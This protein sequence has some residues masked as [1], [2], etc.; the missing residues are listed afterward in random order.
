MS[1]PVASAPANAAMHIHR[2]D[3]AAPAT[4]SSAQR[5]RMIRIAGKPRLP[6]RTLFTLL[7]P[8]VR[9]IRHENS[10]S[11]NSRRRAMNSDVAISIE[12]ESPTA[13]NVN[14]SRIDSG[15]ERVQSRSDEH[16]LLVLRLEVV[17]LHHR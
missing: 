13:L 9:R 16:S 14:T 17:G 11:L 12:I 8:E 5:R 15:M 1:I 10:P 4:S 3:R 2:S 7:N 6:N